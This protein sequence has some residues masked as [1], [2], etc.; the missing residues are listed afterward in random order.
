METHVTIILS[1]D[2]LNVN[3]TCLKEIILL[4]INLKKQ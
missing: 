1:V 2:F 4:Q 3:F